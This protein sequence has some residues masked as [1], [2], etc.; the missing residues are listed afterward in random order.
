MPACEGGLGS[1]QDRGWPSTNWTA[2]NVRPRARLSGPEPIIWTLVV[3]SSPL[4]PVDLDAQGSVRDADTQASTAIREK[5]HDDDLV[6]RFNAG[7][8]AAFVEICVRYR[9][10]L[11]AVAKSMLRNDSDAE[12]IAQDTFVRAYRGLA[13]FRGDASLSTWLHCI[14][15]NLS[16][17]RYWYFFRRHR[18]EMRSFD[19][20]IS[21]GSEIT[22]G[23]LLVCDAPDPAGEAGNHEFVA[24]VME[25]MEILSTDQ[26]EILSLR[27][28]LDQSYEGIAQAL[29][30]SL[31]T[32]KSR[33][34]RARKSLRGLLFEKYA[35]VGPDDTDNLLE[36]GGGRPTNALD[37]P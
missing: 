33:I 15:L 21:E 4:Y 31:G 22:L 29:G 23:D 20:P 16:R 30:L 32:V 19:I 5:N 35:V 9:L 27:G 34:A 24:Q 37:R 1:V 36:T 3:I 12:E 14:A 11:I 7:D 2:A 13:R 17:N 26:R 25:C 10:R 6:R 18:H 8:E 28:I